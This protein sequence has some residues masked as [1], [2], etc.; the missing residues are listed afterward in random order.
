MCLSPQ[1]KPWQKSSSKRSHTHTLTHTHRNTHSR[2][3][4]TYT[5]ENSFLQPAL[6][7]A[8]VSYFWSPSTSWNSTVAYYHQSN[9]A[10]LLGLQQQDT[11]NATKRNFPLITSSPG[12]LSK[13]TKTGS[14]DQGCGMAHVTL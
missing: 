5:S 14:R 4:Q 2:E 7:S 13:A 9:K 11:C 3:T 1:I 8:S 6:R 10:H 12:S